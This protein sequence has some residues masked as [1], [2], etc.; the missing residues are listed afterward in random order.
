ML[1]KHFWNTAAASLLLM[2]AAL[3]GPAQAQGPAQTDPHMQWWRDARFGMFIHWGPISVMGQEISW[4]RSPGP[5]GA[6]PGG[7]PAA[8]YDNLYKQFNPTKFDA[9]AIVAMA[10][11][12]GMK[13][14][15]F[16]CKH[17]DGFCEFDSKLTDY[18][19]TNPESPYDK[20][21]VKQLADATHAAGLHWCVYYSQPDYH[22]PDFHVNQ[23]AYDQYFHRQVHELLTDYGKVD[24]IWFDGLGGTAQDWD[25]ENLFREMRADNP[26][27]II[28]N[29]CGLPGDYYTPEQTIGSY[30]D[31]KPWET[32]M[33]IGDQWAYKPGDNYKSAKQCI[34]TLARCVGGDGNLLLNIGPQSDG[35]VDPTQ[36]NR[37]QAIAG[38]MKTHSDAVAGTRGG[39]YKPTG[40]Y[41]STRKGDMVYIHVLNWNGE[42]IQL[43]PL[44]R[45]IVKS[46]LL[47]GG[48]IA[49][50]QSADGVTVHIPA[51]A[52]DAA[53]TVV[54]LKLGGS[55]MDLAPI[56]PMPKTPLATLSAS[57]VFRNDPTYAAGMAFDADEETRWATDDGTK[58][59][60][61]TATF[62]KPTTVQGIAIKE[63]IEE[64]VQKFEI[65]Y[66]QPG[67]SDWI[68]VASG[69][70]I[71][72]TYQAS[73]APVTARA[74][75]LNILD[76]T[77]GPT[78]SEI[79]FVTA[80]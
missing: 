19:I 1:T 13:Y 15:V 39:P 9:K 67:G 76:A 68:T 44:S 48:R 3:A 59:A 62:E 26:N 70:K 21:I 80:K 72:N 34:Q 63:A 23:A 79:T 10:K 65:Q 43:P 33:T 17:H 31:Q 37:L 11:A 25:A 22:N 42:D 58:Q 29:R 50:H 5:G 56:A 38:W 41:V 32:C 64:R 14:I 40:D 24:L 7:I 12:A 52:H 51:S 73:F 78:I 53:D 55:A 61:L 20:D 6:N 8:T 4:S 35:A 2:G 71:G 54:A 18:K 27:L 75:R 30:D 74:F 28:N 47:G 16:T 49:V 57:D 36:A 60:T 66:Q 46:A 77:D 45:K 69:A